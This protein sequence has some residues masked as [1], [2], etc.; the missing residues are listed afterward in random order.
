MNTHM[1]TIFSA[2]RCT[3]WFLFTSLMK[4]QR[5]NDQENQYG[6]IRTLNQEQ[7]SSEC[8]VLC[9]CPDDMPTRL[10]LCD[11]WSVV[12]VTCMTAKA[13]SQVTVAPA[14]LSRMACPVEVSQIALRQRCGNTCLG[15]I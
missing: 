11:Q 13:R 8:R 9:D 12:E 2:H 1:A 15:R 10:S 6:N 7:G 3:P 5:L 14:L 4:V